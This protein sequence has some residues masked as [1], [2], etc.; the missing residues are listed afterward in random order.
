MEI[1]LPNLNSSIF[2]SKYHYDKIE[3]KKKFYNRNSS[4]ERLTSGEHFF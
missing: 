4:I 3:P 1:R 2:S